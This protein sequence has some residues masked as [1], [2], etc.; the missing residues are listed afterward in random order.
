MFHSRTKPDPA[1]IAGPSTA[2]D[3]GD[4]ASAR[5]QRVQAG[6]DELA[7]LALVLC[8]DFQSAA[9]ET[10]QAAQT[11]HDHT[12]AQGYARAF[13]RTAR[14]YRQCAA[15]ADRL[16]RQADQHKAVLIS[17]GLD[18]ET[19]VQARRAMV[20]RV[21]QAY[22]ETAHKGRHPESERLLADLNE[23]LDSFDDEVFLT[24]AIG[25]IARDLCESHGVIFD[26]SFWEQLEADEEKGIP[27][28]P[29]YHGCHLPGEAPDNP[30]PPP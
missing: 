6:L 29:G 8:R 5:R 1:P 22:V 30:W 9:V 3:P 28:G 19:N 23:T 10:H 20:G 14:C 17:K 11:H 21:A 15:L 24:T 27:P 13:D 12:A 25:Q 18:R 26:L 4:P 16:L 2:Q 7:D